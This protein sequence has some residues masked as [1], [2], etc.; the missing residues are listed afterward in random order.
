MFRTIVDCIWLRRNG[1]IFNNKWKNTLGLV[2]SVWSGVH[3]ICR[4]KLTYMILAPS[5][6]NDNHDASGRWMKPL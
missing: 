1:F 3:D 6:D 5:D 4:N 2:L